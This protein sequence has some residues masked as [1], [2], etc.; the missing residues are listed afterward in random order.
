M[1]SIL[2]TGGYGFIGSN[3]INEVLGDYD[4]TN[5]D[6]MTYAANKENVKISEEIRD[7]ISYKH[8]N[9]DLR[10]KA[11][12]DALFD[13]NHFDIVIHFAAESHVDNSINGPEIFFDT[14]VKGTF[15]L[16]E[17]CRKHW[18][19]SYGNHR[20]IMVS[21]DEVYGSLQFGDEKFTTKSQ[22]DPHSPYSASKAAADHMAMS[23]YHTYGLP[24]IVTNCSNNYGP[25]QHVEKLI[26]KIITRALEEL[27]IPIYGDGL[28]IRDWIHVTDHVAALR[29]VI[30]Y[31]I[32][33]KKYLIGANCERNNIE[34]ASSIIRMVGSISN[35]EFVEDRAGHDRRYA[36]DN[37][38][39][40]SE[41]GWKPVI[42]FES[43]IRETIEYYKN[44]KRNELE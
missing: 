33:G 44:K 11:D 17:N 39:I 24:V 12:V 7:S 10:N 4:I 14:N 19:G 2:V 43:G 25:N 6:C 41:I 16:L 13:K 27:N 18:K 31:G 28:N 37:S 15:N 26:P 40:E 1:K 22:Y 35:I 20:F 29:K 34:V 38:E 5:L 30:K 9:I 8:V 21:T 36:I 42:D 23:Y 3:F 32:P